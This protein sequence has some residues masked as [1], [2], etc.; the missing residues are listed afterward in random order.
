MV[1]TRDELLAQLP[2]LKNIVFVG[3]DA[4]LAPYGKDR[5]RSL[6]S[7]FK[8]AAAHLSVPQSMLNISYRLSQPVA[9]L[10]SS[11][12]IYDRQLTYE[13]NPEQDDLFRDKIG[14]LLRSKEGTSKFFDVNVLLE[15][16]CE[17]N[18]NTCTSLAWIHI[19]APAH[20]NPET[21]SKGNIQEAR[22]IA[23]CVAQLL[24]RDNASKPNEDPQIVI[25]TGYLEQKE[26][27]EK[28]LITELKCLKYVIPGN[29]DAWVKSS[30]IVNATL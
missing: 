6:K 25:L 21:K 15:R 5:V 17:S 2:H 26:I 30:M 10:L 7:P 23:S 28:E 29:I 22:I 1:R 27:I 4:Q 13:R 12:I 3:N 18:S 24:V 9:D 19:N 20:D 11:V 16:F 8:I 14:T